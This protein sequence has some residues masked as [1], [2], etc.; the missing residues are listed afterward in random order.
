MNS[1]ADKLVKCMAELTTSRNINAKL[2]IEITHVRQVNEM[3]RNEFRELEDYSVFLARENEALK[4]KLSQLNRRVNGANEG[5]NSIDTTM[6]RGVYDNTEG[7]SD[8]D[9]DSNYHNDDNYNSNDSNDDNYN[10]NDSNDIDNMI[11]GI[12]DMA[13]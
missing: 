13:L 4:F 5:N 10:S 2:G 1:D 9:D 8:S 12:S 3:L 7:L 11:D 6:N